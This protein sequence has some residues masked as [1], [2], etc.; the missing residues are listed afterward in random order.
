M[1]IQHIHTSI[2]YKYIKITKHIVLS[3]QYCCQLNLTPHAPECLALSRPRCHHEGGQTL[4]GS[5]VHLGICLYQSRS[6][7][8]QSKLSCTVQRSGLRKRPGQCWLLLQTSMKDLRKLLICI[9]HFAAFPFSKP[10]MNPCWFPQSTNQTCGS[11]NRNKPSSDA[12]KTNRYYSPVRI[13]LTWHLPPHSENPTPSTSAVFTC[14]RPG[15]DRGKSRYAKHQHTTQFCM[16][17]KGVICTYD[18]CT[19]MQWNGIVIV[20]VNVMLCYVCR[21]VSVHVCLYV[22][23]CMYACMHACMY[24][25]RYGSVHVCLYVYVCM[26]V[27]MSVCMYVCMYVCRYGSVHVCLYVYV[28]M[29]VCM[30]VCMYVCLY[31]CMYVCMSVCLYVCMSVW[32]DGWMDG[33]VHV[34]M[35]VCIYGPVSRVHGP[36]P[37]HPPTPAPPVHPP[38]HPPTTSTGAEGYIDKCIDTYIYIPYTFAHIHTTYVYTRTCVYIYYYIYIYINNLVTYTYIYVYNYIYIA[39]I[40]YTYRNHHHL[41]G[42]GGTT[43]RWAIYIY[44]YIHTHR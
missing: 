42:E 35:C 31:V 40:Q 4:V 18:L 21:Y 15:C 10:N 24:V 28:C 17:T 38:T 37:S 3:K 34:C 11:S 20:I 29:Y 33:C 2:K 1:Y 43:K 5:Q 25:C 36:P 27:C 6:Y 30:S 19:V 32:M 22:Y 8:W 12:T 26:S 14:T 16:S 9:F 41:G 7:V 39:F 44:N 23:V 13:C